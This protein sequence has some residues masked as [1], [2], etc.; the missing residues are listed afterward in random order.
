MADRLEQI[1][2]IQ[3]RTLL[4][5]TRDDS[6]LS[7]IFEVR[8]KLEKERTAWNRQRALIVFHASY[9]G[10]VDGWMVCR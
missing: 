9:A 4:I 2:D 3:S 8:N 6:V 5:M 10:E 1:G 7:N